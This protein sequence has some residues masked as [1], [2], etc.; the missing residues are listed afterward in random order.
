MVQRMLRTASRSIKKSYIFTQMIYATQQCGV[1]RWDLE[2]GRSQLI[3]DIYCL[4]HVTRPL[5]DT[6]TLEKMGTFRTETFH[7]GLLPWYF[8]QHQDD[9]A[10]VVCLRYAITTRSRFT[11]TAVPDW[12]LGVGLGS[13]KAQHGISLC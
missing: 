8:T 5:T 11:C 6:C 3:K 2:G 7:L 1:T 4:R 12:K 10:S 9:T 13:T